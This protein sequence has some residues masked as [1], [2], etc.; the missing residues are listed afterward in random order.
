MDAAQR[1]HAALT[2]LA[3]SLVAAPHSTSMAVAIAGDLHMSLYEWASQTRIHVRYLSFGMMHTAQ[4]YGPLSS[5]AQ[6][7][8]PSTYWHRGRH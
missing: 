3:H 2:D 8:L 1:L 5:S 7:Q 4:C 6:V